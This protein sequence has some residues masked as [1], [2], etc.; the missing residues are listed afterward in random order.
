M[1]QRRRGQE[2]V[3]NQTKWAKNRRKIVA[4]EQER[5]EWHKTTK[6][7]DTVIGIAVSIPVIIVIE[8]VL[9]EFTA[10]PPLTSTFGLSMMV[11][12]L[13]MSL[14]HIQSVIPSHIGLSKYRL[15]LA[16]GE[17]R[18]ESWPWNSISKCDY[19]KRR[20]RVR[21]HWRSGLPKLLNTREHTA[22]RIMRYW[23]EANQDVSLTDMTYWDTTL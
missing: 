6:D 22:R 7:R 10:V 8:I 9:V 1:S 19:L 5:V 20:K 12:G 21:I 17:K 4:G 13:V 16:Y 14:F 2:R 15:I 11:I 3:L 18:Q 23:I